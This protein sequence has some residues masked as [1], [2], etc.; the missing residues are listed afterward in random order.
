MCSCVHYMLY[1]DWLVIAEYYVL[2]VLWVYYVYFIIGCL[3][4][5]GEWL[6][7]YYQPLIPPVRKQ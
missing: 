6:L 7:Q 5:M 4:L 3:A 1:F 2:A